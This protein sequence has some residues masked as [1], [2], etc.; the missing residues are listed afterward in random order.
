MDFLDVLTREEAAAFKLRKLYFESGYSQYKMSKFEEYELYVRNKD[1][2]VSDNVI[3]F[4]DTDG[5]L[6]ALKPDVTLSII[7]NN[8]DAGDGVK[9]L[10]YNENVYRVSRGTHSFR[11]IMQVG[12]E[13]IGNIGMSEIKE[14]LGL[15]VKSL[16]ALSEDYV[17]EISHLDIV[18]ALLEY[19]AFS[20]SAKREFYALLGQKNEN[21]IAA[22]VK[23]QGAPLLAEELLC[24]LAGLYGRPGSV[25]QGLEK[26]R[27]CPEAIRAIDELLEITTALTEDIP[28]ADIFVDFSVVSDVKYYNGIAIKGFIDGV[29]TSVL[30]GGQYDSLMKRMKRDARAIGFAVYLDELD[31]LP[32]CEVSEK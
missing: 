1:F 31:R 16:R 32:F 27:V 28:N 5:R 26:Y 25:T 7:K 22:L 17:L 21:G 14:V 19:F 11:E 13:C 2:L 20:D 24:G 4:T 29:P 23:R 15:A 9:K 6:L 10:Y 3:T 30:S 8:R 18:G 12:L